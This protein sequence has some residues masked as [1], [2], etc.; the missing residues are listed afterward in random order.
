MTLNQLKNEVMNDIKSKIEGQGQDKLVKSFILKQIS[1]NNYA[2]VLKTI[3]KGEQLT[4]EV[5]V[6]SDGKTFVWKKK[7]SFKV[8][9]N[10]KELKK[11]IIINNLNSNNISEEKAMKELIENYIVQDDSDISSTENFKVIK[12]F[13]SSI[14]ENGLTTVQKERDLYWEFDFKK[15]YID[16]TLNIDSKKHFYTGHYIKDDFKKLEIRKTTGEKYCDLEIEDNQIIQYFLNGKEWN[17]TISSGYA[18]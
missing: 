15:G 4:Y 7:Q 2:G 16:I 17:H 14:I 5:S 3:E 13:F 11:D 18:C 10:E 6:I 12:T 8:V 9:K 1:Q